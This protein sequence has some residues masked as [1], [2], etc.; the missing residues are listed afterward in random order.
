MNKPIPIALGFLAGVLLAASD[1]RSQP[2]PCWAVQNGVNSTIQCAN[3]Y[4]RTITP[5][6]DEYVG[7]GIV[8][9]NEQSVGGNFVVNKATGGP[10]INIMTAPLITPP[11]QTRPTVGPG[12][13]E[14]FGQPVRQD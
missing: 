1:S 4:W 11:A 2:V 13:A 10:N 6:G 14:S 7:M 5:E 9:P 8:D 3:G 12:Q